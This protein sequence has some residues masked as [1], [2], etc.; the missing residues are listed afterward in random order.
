MAIPQDFDD[1]NEK[2]IDIIQAN[3][4][5]FPIH[6]SEEVVNESEDYFRGGFYVLP[7]P[8]VVLK[9]W[10]ELLDTPDEDNGN[11]LFD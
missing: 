6:V 8:Q 11:F 9:L 5:G 4:W 7:I 10:M 3:D 1:T 2:F